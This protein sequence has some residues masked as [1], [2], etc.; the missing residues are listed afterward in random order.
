MA[1]T[2]QYNARMPRQMIELATERAQRDQPGA[3]ISGH[4]GVVRYAVA[5]LAGIPRDQA[6]KELERGYRMETEKIT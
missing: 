6:A 2:G 5:L 4:S 1:A 3:K